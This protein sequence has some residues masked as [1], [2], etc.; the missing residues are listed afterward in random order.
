[1]DTMIIGNCYLIWI[2]L[3]SKYG[4]PRNTWV[5]IT[6]KCHYIHN[7]GSHT[8]AICSPFVCNNLFS[9][10]LKLVY[11]PQRFIKGQFGWGVFSSKFDKSLENKSNLSNSLEAEIVIQTFQGGHQTFQESYCK[12]V[13]LKTKWLV[14]FTN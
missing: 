14:S 5:G 4:L 9:R 10:D 3:V 8:W 2:L 11:I 12:F 7:S 1:M 13:K 6:Q